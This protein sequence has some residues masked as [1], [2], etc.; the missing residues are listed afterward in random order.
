MNALKEYVVRDLGPLY[1]VSPL[2]SMETLFDSA[3]KV[4]PIVFVLS[5]GADP[6]ERILGYAKKQRC[7]DRLYQKSLGQGQERAASALIEEGSKRGYWILLQN[8]HLF[9]SWMPRLDAICAALRD[10]HKRIHPKFRLILTSMPVDYFPAAI[11]QNGVKMTTEPPQGLKANLK[12]IFTNVVDKE[13]YHSAEASLEEAARFRDSGAGLS[14]THLLPADSRSSEQSGTTPRSAPAIVLRPSMLPGFERRFDLVGTW[15]SLLFGLS[16]FHS[17]IQE[18]KKF[19]SLGWNKRYEFNDSDLETSVKMLQNFLF[20]QESIPFDSMQFMTGHINYG[21]RVTDDNDRVLLISL[22]NQCYGKHILDPSFVAGESVAQKRRQT[23]KKRPELPTE[24]FTFFGSGAYRV[25]SQN[26]SLED[27]HAYIDSLPEADLPE[28]FGMH[29]N[30]NI[31]YQQS[32]SNLL[33]K[34]TLDVS[35]PPVVTSK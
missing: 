33:L 17:V 30:A 12:R 16:F 1:A 5:Q 4:T 15:K 35:I 27:V 2:T 23:T 7:Q 24:D 22:L 3:D 25:P 32:E 31:A 18:R 19:G 11:L 10:D 13:V 28:V 21:G 26:H 14:S 29:R 8:C 6:N 34:T 20:D 9:K